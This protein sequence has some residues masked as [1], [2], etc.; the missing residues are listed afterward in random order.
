M[1]AWLQDKQA[2]GI[3]TDGNAHLSLRNR[4]ERRRV[5]KLSQLRVQAPSAHAPHPG[6]D[7]PGSVFSQGSDLRSKL[8][9]WSFYRWSLLTD[10]AAASCWSTARAHESVAI[11]PCAGG[12]Q[13]LATLPGRS[14]ILGNP[15]QPW[16]HGGGSHSL[17]RWGPEAAR[18]SD[19]GVRAGLT[20]PNPHGLSLLPPS[21]PHPL[22]CSEFLIQHAELQTGTVIFKCRS[23][24]QWAL[25]PKNKTT[26]LPSTVTKMSEYK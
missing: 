26:F 24:C 4:Q 21:D 5:D 15:G 20:A 10:S 14:A 7:Q 12:R 25:Q 1:Q 22:N 6:P 2:A 11:V 23:S 13:V 8:A 17:R 16:P 18:R 19:V 9:P 3:F